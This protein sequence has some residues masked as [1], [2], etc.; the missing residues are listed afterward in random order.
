MKIKRDALDD[1]FSQYIRMKADNHCEYCGQW[2]ELSDL[3]CSHFH[4]RRKWITR[5]DEENCIALCSGCHTFLG[6]HPDIHSDF[7]KKKLA[8]Y[9]GQ[10][11]RDPWPEPRMPA[12]RKC[13]VQL[14]LWQSQIENHSDGDRLW[15]AHSHR[16][17]A[18]ES[19]LTK[20][21]SVRVGP[22]AAG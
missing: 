11:F 14:R 3:E 9:R 7:Y 15:R 2:K 8:S 4:G 12:L 1:V 10:A 20:S 13:D 18:D 19:G 17:G 6:E 5:V 16:G 21:E 22:E